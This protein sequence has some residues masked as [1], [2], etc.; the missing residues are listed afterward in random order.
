MKKEK[1]TF[2]IDENFMEKEFKPFCNNNL[3]KLSAVVEDA[4]I[5]WLENKKING[6]VFK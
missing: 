4:L 1:Y 5:K 3:I 2:T 6:L